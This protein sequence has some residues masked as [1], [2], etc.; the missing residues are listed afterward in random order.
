MAEVRLGQIPAQPGKFPNP[1]NG[2]AANG[3]TYRLDGESIRSGQ[4]EQE[5]LA[6]LAQ[7]VDRVI[8]L[9]RRFRRQPDSERKDALRRFP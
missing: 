3:A 2:L 8:H 9:Q 7:G 5:T 4:I 1:H 6:G